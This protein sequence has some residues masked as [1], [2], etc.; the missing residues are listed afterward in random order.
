[1]EVTEKLTEVSSESG[2]GD[3][4]EAEEMPGE[5]NV[6]IAFEGQ[7]GTE[8]KGT[9]EPYPSVA[10][11]V[12]VGEEHAVTSNSEGDGIQAWD[13][14]AHEKTS[15]QAETMMKLFQTYPGSYRK[16]EHI[17]ENNE[18]ET[19]NELT[20]GVPRKIRQAKMK[21][22]RKMCGS[23]LIGDNELVGNSVMLTCRYCKCAILSRLQKDNYVC[24]PGDWKK[25]H[26]VHNTSA[27]KTKGKQQPNAVVDCNCRQDLVVNRGGNRPCLAVTGTQ[28]SLCDRELV[29]P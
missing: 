29:F 8:N 17:W 28:L 20:L 11:G 7:G 14:M 10:S 4:N 21:S 16:P 18:F 5:I 6:V 2:I 1:M 23:S 25:D 19:A 22:V 27:R 24:L 3:E 12:D 26:P 15:P 9:I 13:I